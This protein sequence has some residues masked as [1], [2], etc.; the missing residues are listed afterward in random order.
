[1]EDIIKKVNKVA[2]HAANNHDEYCRNSCQKKG[3][4]IY[5]YISC[6]GEIV[7]LE[8]RCYGRIK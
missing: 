4:K 3:K 1:M 2:G 5:P 6:L 8:S 7:S